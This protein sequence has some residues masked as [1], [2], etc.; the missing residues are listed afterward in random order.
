LKALAGEVLL[1]MLNALQPFIQGITEW[2]SKLDDWQKG[3]IGAGLV[4]GKL[5][6]D[7]AKWVLNG[8]SLR[9]GFD[10]GGMKEKGKG[11]LSRMNPFGKKSFAEK[12]KMVAAR[13]PSLGGQSTA[14]NGGGVPK[15][16]KPGDVTK[17]MN[18]K[19]VLQGAAAILIL[20]GALFVFAK[21]LQEFEKLENG[22]ETL[23]IAGVSLAG[24]TVGL[25]ALSKIPKK[26]IL[27][28]ALALAVMGAA[29]IPFAYSMSLMEGISWTTLGVAAAALVVFGAAM[30]ALGAIMFTG[31][32]A[33]IFGAGILA[34]IALGGALA[35]FGLGLQ[36]VVAPIV[37][38]TDSME[39]M[40]NLDFSKAVNGIASIGK[41]MTELESNG[42]LESLRETAMWLS[43]MSMKPIKVEF[44]EMNVSG[45]IELSGEGG[46]KTST[47]WINDPIF[48]SN[49]KD[50]IAQHMAKDQTGSV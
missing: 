30:F 11:V 22:W 36:Q 24:L 49:L 14:G 2:V 19:N 1:P 50:L 42:G 17:G 31:V 5:A 43:I 45:D 29:M 3:F 33:L 13:N 39:T 41:A 44:G 21:A 9:K 32:G 34:F 20:S 37:D 40:T 47:D 15:N 35:I 10:M 6:F 12:R 46:G 8:I 27:T 26:D 25:F 48:V 18:M 28:G 4:F 38:F 7:A 16:G 23:I